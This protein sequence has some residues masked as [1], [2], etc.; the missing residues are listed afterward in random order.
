MKGLVISSG[1]IEDYRQLIEIVKEKDYVLCADGGL[2]HAINAGIKPDGAIGD[3]DSINETIK[4]YLI[5]NNIPI[6]KFPIEKDE[7]D[8]E[9]GIDHLLE[10]GCT[11]ITLVGVTGTRLDHTLANIFILRNL[12]K[13]GVT[14]RIINFNN[15]IYYVD[16]EI[17]FNRKDG[18]YISVIPI[19]SE[20]VIVTLEGFYYPLKDSTI[21]FSSTLGVSNK[22][23]EEYGE[24]KIIKG[25]ALIIEARD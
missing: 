21:N 13:K 10:I 4:E 20:G 3:F 17:S 2:R 25:E 6:Y 11:D 22:I 1:N 7:T 9:L 12:H 24:I 18:Y 16:N 23:V 15:T 19:S 8:T 5:K 14:A